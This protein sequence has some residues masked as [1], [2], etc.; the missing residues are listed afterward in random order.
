MWLDRQSAD[1]LPLSRRGLCSERR[2]D[3]AIADYTRALQFDEHLSEA[4]RG[5]GDA[6]WVKSDVAAALADY[7]QALALNPGDA[8]SL[9]G[10]GR[11]LAA[12]GEHE[13]RSEPP[14]TRR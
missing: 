7:D 12:K 6:E 3:K 14:S 9:Y 13:R 4:H 1:G 5:R 11:A 10:R 8:P 2:A